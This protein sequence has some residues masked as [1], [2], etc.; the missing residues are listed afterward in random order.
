MPL[1]NVNVAEDNTDLDI[2][3]DYSDSMYGARL[4]LVKADDDSH[5]AMNYLNPSDPVASEA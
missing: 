4:Q 5:D 3:V 2:F 1:Y